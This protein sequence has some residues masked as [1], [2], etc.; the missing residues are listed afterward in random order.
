MGWS[1]V[2][3][4]GLAGAAPDH[5]QVCLGQDAQGQGGGRGEKWFK[6]GVD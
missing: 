5:T 6:I 1:P 4:A 3:R 2:H